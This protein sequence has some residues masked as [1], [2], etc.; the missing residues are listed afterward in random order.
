MHHD[1]LCPLCTGHLKA[2]NKIILTAQTSTYQRGLILLDPKLGDYS[3]VRHPEFSY[4]EGEAVNFFCPICQGKLS[5][6]GAGLEENLVRLI[7]RDERGKESDVFFSKIAGEKATYTVRDKRV[8][9]YGE[10]AERYT[11]YFGETPGY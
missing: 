5:G 9:T 1:Y 10:D 4:Q 6:P 11:N 2:N 3:V 7:M 8:E